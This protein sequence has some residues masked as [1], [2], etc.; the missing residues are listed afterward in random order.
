MSKIII[1]VIIIIIIIIIHVSILDYLMNSPKQPA[2]ISVCFDL[3]MFVE[4][5]KIT[6]L[7][8]IDKRPLPSRK[9]SP[10]P[11]LSVSCFCFCWVFFFFFTWK[12][13]NN[14]LFFAEIFAKTATT[15]IS[16][17]FHFI[18]FFKLG[19]VAIKNSNYENNSP[20]KTLLWI[21]T[22]ATV[23]PPVVNFKDIL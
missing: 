18:L 16:F 20:L 13:K 9:E 22:S 2:E 14:S 10:T 8:P 4:V 12:S 3:I 11:A 7:R 1:I 15:N 17:I 23:C 5:D 21:F 19:I 6:E